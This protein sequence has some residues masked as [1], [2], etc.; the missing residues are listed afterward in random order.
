MKQGTPTSSVV[1]KYTS[2]KL[3]HYGS[4]SALTAAGTGS[5]PEMMMMTNLMMNPFT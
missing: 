5:V 4:L 1:K 2:P 3:V